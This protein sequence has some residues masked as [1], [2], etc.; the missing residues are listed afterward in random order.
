MDLL[1]QLAV[2]INRSIT[3]SDITC[4]LGYL[5]KGRSLVVY[6]IAGSNVVQ[7]YMD[8][9]KLEDFNFEIAM[10]SKSEDEINQTL[11]TI[12]RRLQ[13]THSIVSKNGSFEFERLTV[14]NMPFL[15]QKDEQGWNVFLTNVQIRITNMNKGD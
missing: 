14:T 10:R 4:K 9:T 15:N 8:G 13:N 6:P 11:W 3:K 5:G 7:S 2:E 12:I 1:E